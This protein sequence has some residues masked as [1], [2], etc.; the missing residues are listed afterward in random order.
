MFNCSSSGCL[1]FFAREKALCLCQGTFLTARLLLPSGL[2]QIPAPSSSNLSSDFQPV[3]GGWLPGW[4]ARLSCKRNNPLLGPQTFWGPYRLC[5]LPAPRA[6][7]CWAGQTLFLP[8]SC[9][10]PE[11]GN[12]LLRPS[13][14][15]PGSPAWGGQECF[16]RIRRAMVSIPT[17]PPC[18]CISG[19][20]LAWDK[21]WKQSDAGLK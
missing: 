7:P 6:R 17:M 20:C 14:S 12:T 11:C 10:L 1:G 18:N 3:R 13:W 9:H 4:G 2:L 5:T 8:K 16:E 21:G 15:E 19:S